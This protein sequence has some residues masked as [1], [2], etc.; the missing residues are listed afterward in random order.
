MLGAVHFLWNSSSFFIVL[1]ICNIAPV[2]NAILSGILYH[3]HT[4]VL[5]FYPQEYCMTEFLRM[6][7]IYWGVTALDLMD[8]VEKINQAEI[9]EFIK[10]CQCPFSGGISPCEGHDPHILYTLSAVQVR[11]LC[12]WTEFWRMCHLCHCIW[13]K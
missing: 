5:F 11:F 12:F 8:N 13:S 3:I 9:I 6:S 4:N 7:G 10:K 2:F 1:F